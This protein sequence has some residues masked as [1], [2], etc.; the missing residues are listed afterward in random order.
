MLIGLPRELKAGEQRVGLTPHAVRELV[1]HDH[2]VLVESGA[3]AGIRVSDAEY[4]ASGALIGSCSEV[5]KKSELVVKV[6]E[7]QASERKMLGE[8]QILFAYLH[9]A[10]DPDQTSDLVDSGAAC[11]AYETVTDSR[12]GLPLLAPMSRVAGRLAVQAGAWA[13]ETAHGGIGLL[14]GGVPGVP[15][16]RVVII[17][18]GVVGEN[19]AEIA[20]GMGADVRVLDIDPAALDHLEQR[21]GASVVTV[22][23]TRTTVE[24]EV[25]GADLVIGAVLVTG[26]RAPKLVTAEMISQMRPG[27]VVVDVAIDQGGCFETS[28]PTTHAEPTF[29][30]DGI[31]HYCV[32]N[33]PGAVPVTSTRALSDATLPRVLSIAENGLDALRTDPHLRAG[34]NVYKG[35]VTEPHVA[36]ALDLPYTDPLTALGC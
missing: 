14:I 9:L 17:G 23:S 27:S 5:W 16:A 4:E 35:H 19:A 24:T 29:V 30:V 25:L 34:L 15:P 13:L 11:V 6:K 32:A 12:G 20:I 36:A 28:K 33:M 1:L 10:P 7:P 26:A 21:F 18:G 31:V 8:G 3:G 2:Q 22:T